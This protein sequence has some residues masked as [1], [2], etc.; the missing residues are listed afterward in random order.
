MTPKEL[1]QAQA[2][3]AKR[4]DVYSL[5]DKS[6][7][8]KVYALEM[9]FPKIDG[10]VFVFSNEQGGAGHE[11]TAEMNDSACAAVVSAL[12]GEIQAINQQ[13][14]ALGLDP[15]APEEPEEQEA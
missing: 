15:D 2:L 5:I 13:L 14:A 12:N 7:G 1:R 8:M 9:R 4:R 6:E 10:R 3:L 11:L